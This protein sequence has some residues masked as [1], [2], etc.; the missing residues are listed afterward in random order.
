[1]TLPVIDRISRLSF[2]EKPK[3]RAM[4]ADYIKRLRVKTASPQKP[5]RTLSGGNAQK[6]VLAKWL[7][8]DPLLLILDEPTAGVDIGNRRSANEEEANAC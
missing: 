8:T 2:V 7:A 3:E 5:V 6:V 1:M 4:V